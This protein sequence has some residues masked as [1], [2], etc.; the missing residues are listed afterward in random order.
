MR[1]CWGRTSGLRRRAYRRSAHGRI[2]RPR[3]LPES[4][5]RRALLACRRQ[6]FSQL[7]DFSG[8]YEPAGPIGTLLLMEGRQGRVNSDVKAVTGVDL[9]RSRRWHKIFERMGIFYPGKGLTRLGRLG[10]LLRDAA[11]PNGMKLVVAREALEVLRRY[12]FDNP[13]ERSLPE[14][15]SI[16]PYYAVLRAASKLDWK[17]HWDELNR[18]LMR[19]MTD[20]DLDAAIDKIRVARSDPGYAAFIGSASND[21]GALSARTHAAEATAPAGKTPEGQLRDQQMTPFLKRT[22]SVSCCLN[23]PAVAARATGAFQPMFRISCWRQSLRRPL[24]SYVPPNRN[25][26]NGSARARRQPPSPYHLLHR[27]Q[28]CYRSPQ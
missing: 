16:H 23:R 27:L 2:G 7:G 26:S 4:T 6:G 3:H 13:V 9:N 19:I 25:G 24:R 1:A 8:F 11:Q 5:G 22:G 15:C 14:G 28:S 20:S 18:E 21:A 10:R 12:Q 17:I